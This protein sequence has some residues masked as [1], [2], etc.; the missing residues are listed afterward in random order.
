MDNLEVQPLAQSP[1][2]NEVVRQFSHGLGP[3]IAYPDVIHAVADRATQERER[4][5]A[6]WRPKFQDQGAAR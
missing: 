3:V 1:E 5:A 4:E 6:K 2:D